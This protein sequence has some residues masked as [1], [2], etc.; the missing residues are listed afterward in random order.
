M[1]IFLI[2]L[3]LV[4]FI[5]FLH[6]PYIEIINNKNVILWYTSFKNERKWV[7]LY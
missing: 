5:Y 4:L 7:L 3:L 6:K 1:T 2:I